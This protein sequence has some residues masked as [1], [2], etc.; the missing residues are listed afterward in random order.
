M[1][2]GSTQY[3]PT[4]EMKQKLINHIKN[5]GKLGGST[6]FYDSNFTFRLVQG[7]CIFAFRAIPNCYLVFILWFNFVLFLLLI[8]LRRM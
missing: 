2:V 7:W 5:T 8:L 6:A 1:D 4:E 3:H